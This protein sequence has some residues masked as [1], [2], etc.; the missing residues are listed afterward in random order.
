MI[1]Y[2]YTSEIPFEV[3]FQAKKLDHIPMEFFTFDA[4]ISIPVLIVIYYI[5]VVSIPLLTIVNR[6]YIVKLVHFLDT[7]GT[8]SKGKIF[9]IFSVFFIIFQIVWRMMFEMLIGYFHMH[10]YLQQLAG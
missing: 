10:D 2:N 1:Q 5:G 6:E 3:L 8:L 4:F 7:K 9:T